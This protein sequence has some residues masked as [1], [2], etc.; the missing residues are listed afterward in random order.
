MNLRRTGVVLRPNPSRVLFR[1]LH[2]GSEERV[3]R[4]VQRVLAMSEEGVG[5]TLKNVFLDFG[6]RH[7]KLR[8]FFLTRFENVCPPDARSPVFSENR[9]LLI[10]AYFSQEYSLE[11]A[12]LFNPSI[13][14]HPDQSGLANG[15]L[16]FI[17]SLRATGEG[18]LSSI[19]FRTGRVTAGGEINLETPTA[20]LSSPDEIR[21][22]PSE[23]SSFRKRLSEQGGEPMVIEPILARL[24]EKF[25]IEDLQKEIQSFGESPQMRHLGFG[26]TVNRMLAIASARYEI[27][28][29]PDHPVTERVIFPHSPDEAAGIEDA[30]FVRF[31]ENDGTFS[32]VATY[33][34]Y[35][36]RSVHPQLLETE[37]FLHFRIQPLSGP[38]IKNKGM[39]LF[40][41]KIG[42][43]Y[44]MLSRQDGEN[45]YLMFSEDL[46]TWTS[47]K[48]LMTPGS[49]W[50]F[51]QV[52]NCGSP[53]K[54]D[55][56][57]LVLTHGV[58]AMRKYSIGAL[59][60]DNDDPSR[61]IRRLDKPLL[62]P[63]ENER[64]GYVPNVV[65][66]CGALVHAGNLILP[67]AMSD[68]AC[69]FATIGVQ[70]LLK[71]M[72]VME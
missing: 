63:D 44:A 25:L 19:T 48:P 5:E 22:L 3:S 18:H 67:Y 33:T 50:E 69:S 58:G 55:E 35:D 34:A 6:N 68:T 15:E 20:L 52:G 64:E 51:F 70:D 7:K 42:G 72:K 61:V 30:R 17:V 26:H 46:Y 31:R 1:P 11:A 10:G 47:K 13:V 65:Y 71:E 62:S 60:L 9:R 43:H 66:S 53:I 38:E 23:K 8:D 37:D 28:Y 41:E 56:G 32:Y 36:G 29:S 14:P 24:E 59:L 16:R 45:L 49:P 57:W 54:L 39:A 21:Y 27:F 2:P 40:P 12:A 4:I